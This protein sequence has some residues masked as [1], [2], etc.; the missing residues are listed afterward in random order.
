MGHKED[1]RRRGLSVP[2]CRLVM[3]RDS[4]CDDFQSFR[5]FPC[6]A[7]VLLQTYWPIFLDVL[8]LECILIIFRHFQPIFRTFIVEEIIIKQIKISIML[9][10]RAFLKSFFHFGVMMLFIFRCQYCIFN[11]FKDYYQRRLYYWD[12]QLSQSI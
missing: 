5:A 8:Y 3:S 12:R 9:S 2:S 7:C 10:K 11:N 6:L 1:G 4:G